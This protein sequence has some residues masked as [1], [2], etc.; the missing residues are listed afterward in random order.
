M[1]SGKPSVD[2]VAPLD[3]KAPVRH[4]WRLVV[5][6]PQGFLVGRSVWQ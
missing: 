5:V 1:E 6:K 3:N 2:Q 4:I